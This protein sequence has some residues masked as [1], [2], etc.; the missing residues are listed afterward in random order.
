DEMNS[1][2][3]QKRNE[4][5]EIYIPPGPRLGDKVIEITHLKKSYAD[6]LLIDDLSFHVPKG[7]I[8]GI[9]G[10]NGAGKSTLFRMI[11]GT[12]Q[13]DSGTISLGD[14]V[15]LSYVD[16]SRDQ[17]DGSKTVWEEISG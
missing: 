4:T 7:G 8:V 12:E 11:N 3:F 5:N 15:Q 2:E 17:L 14:S 16:Q 10:G 13:P 9:I 1:Q 6:R